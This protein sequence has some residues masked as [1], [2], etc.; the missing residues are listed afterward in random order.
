MILPKFG[1][2]K[3][4]SK[5]FHYASFLPAPSSRSLLLI[6]VAKKVY[7]LSVLCSLLLCRNKAQ[8]AIDF[9]SLVPL[10][11]CKFFEC[12]SKWT[13]MSLEQK[14]WLI[15]KWNLLSL[16]CNS[17]KMNHFLLLCC[18]LQIVFVCGLLH[19]PLCSFSH[20]VIICGWQWAISLILPSSWEGRKG[21]IVSN[22]HGENVLQGF[23]AIKSL[24]RSGE[25]DTSS[26]W[27][28]KP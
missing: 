21:S 17:Y 25:R 9:C 11:S 16:Y 28:G 14:Y 19:F 1:Q 13:N 10:I 24:I 12:I 18:K 26:H 3:L 4:N 23:F 8:E 22:Y 20:Q 27:C 6:K 5:T 7:F 15:F 2:H